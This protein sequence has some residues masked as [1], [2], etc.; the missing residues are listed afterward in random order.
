MRAFAVKRNYPSYISFHTRCTERNADIARI[1]RSPSPSTSIRSSSPIESAS[2]VG[3]SGATAARP[4][5][6]H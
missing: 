1:V 3:A 2:V 6:E 5:L 4:R